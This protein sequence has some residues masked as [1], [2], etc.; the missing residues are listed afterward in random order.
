MSE[1]LRVLTRHERETRRGTPSVALASAKTKGGPALVS[2][3]EDRIARPV[4]APPPGPDAG[5]AT[6]TAT[7][8]SRVGKWRARATD[9][10]DEQGAFSTPDRSR[11]FEHL[12]VVSQV[13]TGEDGIADLED[14]IGNL[15]PAE[16]GEGCIWRIFEKAVLPLAPERDK[17]AGR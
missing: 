8:G 14:E 12:R 1:Y 15:R 9:D 11:A 2:V 17:T 3:A 16:N 7:C 13:I 6:D 5:P 4:L 10:V